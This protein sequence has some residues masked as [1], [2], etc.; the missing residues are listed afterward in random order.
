[1]RTEAEELLLL[2]RVHAVLSGNCS[3]EPL[4]WRERGFTPAE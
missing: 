1:M 3:V 4:T 2:A